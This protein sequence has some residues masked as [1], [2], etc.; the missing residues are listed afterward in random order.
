MY[1]VMVEVSCG[2]RALLSVKEP[3]FVSEARAILPIVVRPCLNN[4]RPPPERQMHA[5]VPSWG[6]GTRVVG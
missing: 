4:F 1:G 6:K 3:V 5:S 2:K